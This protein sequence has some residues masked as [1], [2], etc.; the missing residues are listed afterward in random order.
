MT[1]EEL[2]NYKNICDEIRLH[3]FK[4]KEVIFKS[5]NIDGLGIQNSTTS[6]PV[7]DIVQERDRICEEITKLEAEKKSIELYID[8]CDGYIGE[9]LKMHYI[10]GKTWTAIAMIKGGN[11]KGNSLRMTCHRYIEKNP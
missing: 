6:N 4:L 9:M 7:A 8:N 1:K 10:K 2:R 11:N 3:E 5:K